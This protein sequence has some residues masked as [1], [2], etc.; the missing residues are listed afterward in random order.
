MKLFLPQ[1]TL[2]EWVLSEKADL[3]EDRVVIASEKATYPV[4]PAVHFK[5]V[6]SGS[7]DRNLV[8]KVK[9][10]EQ[11]AALGA[12]H[13]ADSVLLGED[14]Y[15]VT[16]GYVTELAVEAPPPQK[17]KSETDLLAS[18]LLDKL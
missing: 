3:K 14:A 15:E 17:P 6:V 7:D 8:H 2:E 18:F 5:A 11:L 9:T 4:V 1:T 10:A 16:E 13:M 12:E